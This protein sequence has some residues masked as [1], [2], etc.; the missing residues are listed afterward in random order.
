VALFLALWYGA[1]VVLCRALRWPCAP[2]DLAAMPL[3]DLLLPVLWGATFATRGF[4]WRGTSMAP[5]RSQAGE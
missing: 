4:V 5:G 1:E 2:R 3:R